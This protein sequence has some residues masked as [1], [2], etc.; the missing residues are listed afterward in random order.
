MK[1]VFII[2]NIITSCRNNGL[3]EKRA[4]PVSGY[5]YNTLYINIL[6]ILTNKIR[7]NYDDDLCN[8]PFSRLLV[9]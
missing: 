4:D 8:A 6:V 2:V 5:V 3:S 9:P 1:T 7:Q